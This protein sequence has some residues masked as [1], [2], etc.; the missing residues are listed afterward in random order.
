ML[1]AEMTQKSEEVT[2]GCRVG[3]GTPFRLGGEKRRPG[4]DA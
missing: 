4:G 2:L 3:W 1:S